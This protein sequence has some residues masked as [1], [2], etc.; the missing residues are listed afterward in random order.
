[1]DTL[2]A[3][4]RTTFSPSE[5]EQAYL[6]LQ[7]VSA[8]A[9]SAGMVNWNLTDN[10]PPDDVAGV[11]LSA[12]RR[13]MTNPNR[14]ISE[15]L[16]PVSV[17]WAPPPDNFFTPG[18]L[19]ILARKKSGSLYT[20]STRREEDAW[21]VGYLHMRADLSD[22]PIPYLNYGEPGFDGTIPG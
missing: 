21:G 16:G 11:I 20:I 9:R 13:E 14:V 15:A 3:F 5:E 4:M 6:I 8:W 1:M 17:T 19:R 2:S 10:L 18:E 22:D 7:V 12:S